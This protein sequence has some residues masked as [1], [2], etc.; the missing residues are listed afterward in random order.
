MHF[1]INSNFESL[2]D[3]LLIRKWCFCKILKTE[4]QNFSI[5]FSTFTKISVLK[6]CFF[7][8]K[9]GMKEELTTQLGEKKSAGKHFI[10][11]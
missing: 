1:K 8:M 7:L 6:N 5:I 11:S 9:N 4:T 2:F 10:L 3:W